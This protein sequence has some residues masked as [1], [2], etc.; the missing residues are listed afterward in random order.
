MGMDVSGRSGNYFRATVWT[1]HP[2]WALCAV[3]GPDL[4]AKVVYA[5][6]NDGDGLD[7]PDARTLA[8]LLTD[9]MDTGVVAKLIAEDQAAR[10]ALAD[11]E[12]RWCAGSGTRTDDVGV[13][14]GMVQRKWCNAC[15][16]R[17]KLR[18]F[19]THYS[20]EEDT[21]VEF[22]DFLAAS[23]GFEIW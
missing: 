8:D 22:R 20:V 18:P 15:D 9:A 4:A 7:G 12:C 23:D 17:G 13:R 2:L 10:D 5:H 19:A 21:V 1:W 3:V 6:S 16:G 11:E 14:L